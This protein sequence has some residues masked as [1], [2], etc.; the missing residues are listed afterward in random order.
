MN[1]LVMSL[2]HRYN[3]P[4]RHRGHR[5]MVN[6][7][8]SVSFPDSQT[9]VFLERIGVWTEHRQQKCIRDWVM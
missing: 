4:Q 1:D 7:G 8:H 5:V 2:D 6:R 3:L 9:P